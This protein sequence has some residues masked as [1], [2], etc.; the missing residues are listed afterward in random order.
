MRERERETMIGCF[1]IHTPTGVCALTVVHTWTG[2]PSHSPG[3][4]Q[5]G[6]RTYDLSFYR[7]M[8][9]SHWPGLN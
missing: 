3:M 1:L 9:E 4:C 7:M 6:N 8:L 2:D 5:T